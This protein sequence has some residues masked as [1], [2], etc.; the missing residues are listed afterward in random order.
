LAAVDHFYGH[1]GLDRANVRR[2]EL[3]RVAPRTLARDQQRR[4][5]RAVECADQR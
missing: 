5:L 1:L 3:P 2:E 4:R